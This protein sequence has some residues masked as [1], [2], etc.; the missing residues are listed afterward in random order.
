MGTRFGSL[1]GLAILTCLTATNAVAEKF[2]L[3]MVATTSVTAGN[4]TAFERNAMNRADN[5]FS[6]ARVLIL[7]QGRINE[8][9]SLYVELPI[10]LSSVSSTW[11]SYVR[12]FIRMEHLGGA[13]W[14]NWQTGKLPTPWGTYGERAG[15]PQNG[16]VSVPL[17]YYYKT[18][19]RPDILPGSP[20]YFFQDGVRGNGYKAVFQGQQRSFHGVPLVYDACWNIGSEV[21]GS[22]KGM[23]YSASLLLGTISKPATTDNFNSGFGVSGRLGY[24]FTSGPL[25]G[26]RVGGSASTGAYLPSS[27]EQDPHFES[28]RRVEDFQN[29]AFGFDAAYSRGSWIFTA[30]GGHLSYDVPNFSRALT[31]N[32]YYAEVK[33]NFGPRWS[34]SGRS[35]RIWFSDITSSEGFT[36]TWDYDLNRWTA[37]ASLRFRQGTRLR[38]EYQQTAFPGRAD[39]AEEL[40]ALQLQVWTR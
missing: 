2:S 14:L 13:E 17:L 12:P 23:E 19:L 33:K 26:L 29:R 21:Y 31:A 38:L 24:L 34:V 18:A 4:N 28:G 36:D 8:S 20:D 15:S 40:L 37:A 35:E 32:S 9:T 3:D 11:L 16:T 10:D 7:T 5:P 30:E 22:D 25:F 1:V 39:L 6:Y 27:A